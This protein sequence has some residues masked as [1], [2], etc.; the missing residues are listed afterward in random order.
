MRRPVLL[1]ASMALA[2]LLFT[3]SGTEPTAAQQSPT[4]PN[5][6]FILADDMRRYDLKY[7]PETRAL[8]GDKGMSF[9][10]AYVSNAMCCP[11]R[12]TIMRGQ[13]AHNTGVWNNDDGPDG[14]WKG[15]KAHGNERDNLATRLQT[16]GYRTALV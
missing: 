1:L 9:A 2:M 8:V 14:G 12:A 16:A 13:Y 6:V 4:K 11:S 15:Y 3:A 10:R 5:F 7:M